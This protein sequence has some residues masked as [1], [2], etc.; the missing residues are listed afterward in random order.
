MAFT[1][2]FNAADDGGWWAAH[3]GE[4]ICQWTYDPTTREIRVTCPGRVN[5]KMR[6]LP[7]EQPVDR[8]RL[9]R[10]AIELVEQITGARY[11]E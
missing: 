10:I 2:H 5:G 8:N 6:A 9:A 1:P 11:D 7:T 3:F 4:R